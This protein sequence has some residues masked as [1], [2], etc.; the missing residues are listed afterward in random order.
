MKHF[1]ILII[2]IALIVSCK[3][4]DPITANATLFIKNNLP[5]GVSL[6][7]ITIIRKDT[8][9][10]KLIKKLT[11][12]DLYKIS[13]EEVEVARA[14]LK[15]VGVLMERAK[16]YQRINMGYLINKEEIKDKYAESNRHIAR[17]DS[18]RKHADSL[19][20]DIQA[21]KFDSI[22][23][24]RYEVVYRLKF[25][26]NDTSIKYLKACIWYNPK[27]EIISESN[28]FKDYLKDYLQ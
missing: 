17:V 26:K 1:L 2:Y 16:L 4:E 3:K 20:S 13:T 22:T 9:T 28:D 25:R 6:D 18:L 19:Y 24:I 21:N 10:D 8:V 23:P 7:S 27:K 12:A 11:V 5:V 14:Q 15:T